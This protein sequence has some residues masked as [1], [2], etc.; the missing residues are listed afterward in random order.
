MAEAQ[1]A[2]L[3]AH[4]FNVRLGGGA[5]VRTR[6]HGVLFC[7]QAE[8]VVTQRMQH[9]LTQHAVIAGIDVGSDITQGVAYVE[10]NTGGVGEH[11]LHEELVFG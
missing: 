3:A 4:V 7:G 5:R 1:A 8:S 11:I 6:L 2:Q 10:A 9:I